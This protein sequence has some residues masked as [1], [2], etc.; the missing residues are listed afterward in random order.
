MGGARTLVQTGKQHAFYTLIV[1]LIFVFGQDQRHQPKPYPLK[2]HLDCKAGQGYPR[3][4]CTT[5]QDAS[6]QEL[7]GDVSFQHLVPELSLNLLCFD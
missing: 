3:F 4:I 2:F 5:D 6:E 1:D 7:L